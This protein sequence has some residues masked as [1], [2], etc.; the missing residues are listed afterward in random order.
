M[1]RGP[2]YVQCNIFKLLMQT[3]KPMTF[4]DIMACAYPPG[5]FEGDMAKEFGSSGIGRVRSLRRALHK[6]VVDGTL[7]AHGKG[8]PADPH[9]YYFNDIFLAIITKH[10]AE[11][12][13]MTRW[14]TER[15]V[16]LGELLLEARG[17]M[18]DQAFYDWIKDKF[19]MSPEQADQF[20]DAACRKQATSSPEPSSQ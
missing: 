5:S 14:S 11:Y 7:T 12:E 2:G 9:R 19:K 10:K 16:R 20:I 8:G 3:K 4:A 6:M 17:G 18:T 15:S 13:E 1:S